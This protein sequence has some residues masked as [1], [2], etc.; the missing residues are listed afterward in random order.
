MDLPP[1]DTF[2]LSRHISHQTK[3]GS[4][5]YL[6]KHENSLVLHSSLNFC[7]I[8]FLVSFS[9]FILFP[10]ED[11]DNSS[12]GIDVSSGGLGWLLGKIGEASKMN[13]DINERYRKNK[14]LI[15]LSVAG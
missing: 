9:V 4:C 2:N 3:K 8:G 14:F 11:D 1:R 5:S 12:D 6:K 7:K 15:T 10:N 13:T